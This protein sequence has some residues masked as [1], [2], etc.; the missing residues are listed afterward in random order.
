MNPLP[1]ELSARVTA[2]VAEDPDAG[3]R[4]EVEALLAQGDEGGLRDRFDHPLAFGTAGLRGPLGAGP[5]RINP[6]VV[7]RTTAGLVSYLLDLGRAALDDDVLGAGG[8]TPAASTGT[9][10][11]KNGGRR[12]PASS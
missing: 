2:W 4:A 12:W 5:G 7:R 11:T 10:S 1:S 8:P 3:S 9:C 6:A